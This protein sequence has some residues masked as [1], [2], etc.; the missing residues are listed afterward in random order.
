MHGVDAVLNESITVGARLAARK[1]KEDIAK[2]EERVRKAE[3]RRCVEKK[4]QGKNRKVVLWHKLR[5]EHEAQKHKAFERRMDREYYESE[6]QKQIDRK[7]ENAIHSHKDR[8]KHEDENRLFG[9]IAG[10]KS[11][12]A[13]ATLGNMLKDQKSLRHRDK[14]EAQRDLLL[15]KKVVALEAQKTRNMLK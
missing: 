13:T 15:L 8:D 2:H 4:M 3:R 1:I 10:P 14:V 11:H 6:E 12:H 7:R 9:K 5:V